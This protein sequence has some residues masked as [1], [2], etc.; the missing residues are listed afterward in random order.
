[1]GYLKPEEERVE[2][3]ISY[4]TR[5]FRRSPE[6]LDGD[7]FAMIPPTPS[8]KRGGAM[9][10]QE[11]GRWVVTLISHFGPAGPAELD[12][13]IEFAKTLPA[14]YIYE[15]VRRAEPIGEASI[16]R[17]PASVRRRY[18]RL[19]RFPNGYLVM[20]D[21]LSS[22]NPIYGQ[23]MSVAALE[24]ME[25][26]AALREGTE[27]LAS[28]FFR[29]VSKVVDI[30]WS[31]AAGNDLRIPDAA[32]RRTFAVNAIN[33]YVAR[34]HK[35]AHYDPVVALAFHKVGHLFVPP[36]SIL[37]PRIALRVLWENLRPHS[38]QPRSS[39]MLTAKAAR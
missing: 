31:I 36:S 23:G 6:D 11:G 33:A 39:Q 34:L 32:G 12:G 8:G 22:F 17:F 1:M 4:T 28:R 2:V 10:A 9:L 7:L 26:Q 19:D 20:G 5:S 35:A 15:V 24:S 30:P 38:K 13:Y 18:E 37:A 25:L 3:G 21:A 27:N 14:P 16:T 29:R